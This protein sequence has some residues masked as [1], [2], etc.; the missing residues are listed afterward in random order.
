MMRSTTQ[1]IIV[2]L[3]A[4]GLIL[5]LT[6]CM[7]GWFTHEQ[8]AYLVVGTPVVTGNHGE[9]IISVVNMPSEGVA[10]IAIDDEGI[11]YTNITGSS[12][13]M[14]GLNGFTVLAQDFTTSAGK[15]SLAAVNAN[16][17]ITGGP[18]LKI[19]FETT[20]NPTFTVTKAK[21]SIGSHLNTLIS[22]A[23]WQLSTGV[24]YY[25]KDAAQEGGAK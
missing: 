23:K 6:A 4:V 22:D 11:T 10:S 19:M 5:A 15:G 16:A 14:E 24:A 8:G 25:A 21:V 13:N 1:R 2:G 20:G 12:V 7:G 3:L 18:I 9:V 17:G